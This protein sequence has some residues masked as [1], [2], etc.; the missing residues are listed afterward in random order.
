MLE[1]PVIIWWGGGGW[2]PPSATA[3]PHA[4]LNPQLPIAV[5]V[6]YCIFL[7]SRHPLRCRCRCC[8]LQLCRRLAAAITVSHC[9]RAAGRSRLLPHTRCHRCTLLHA[10]RIRCSLPHAL[11]LHAFH[12]NHSP[13]RRRLLPHTLTLLAAAPTPPLLH[14]AAR[15]PLPPLLPLPLPPPP[16]LVPR[17]LIALK[18]LSINLCD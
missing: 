15:T 10:R 11:W 3:P 9:N 2:L 8:P 13:S 17:P 4:R 18:K 12:C 6:A 14:T 16:L 7:P 5:I 1:L